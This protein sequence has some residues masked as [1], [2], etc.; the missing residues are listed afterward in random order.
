MKT[1]LFTA[2][3]CALGLLVI[4]LCATFVEM[5]D[6][7]FYNTLTIGFFI[8]YSMIGIILLYVIYRMILQLIEDRR[9]WH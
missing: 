3:I 5:L 7:V 1:F 4:I 6:A 9:N 2:A 8:F